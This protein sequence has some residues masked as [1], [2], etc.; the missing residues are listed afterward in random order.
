MG[1]SGPAQ[2]ST[3]T[4]PTGAAAGPGYTGVIRIRSAAEIEAAKALVWEFFDALRERYPEMHDTL[5][6]YLSE[7][8]VAGGLERFADTFLPPRGESFLALANG[9]PVGMVLLQPHGDNDGEMN[10]MFVR[11]SAR[12]LGLGRKLGQ[13][14][15]AEARAI[16]YGTVWLDAL[17][18]HV[19]ALPLY[20]SLGFEYY[21][22]PN[23]FQADDDRVIHMKLKL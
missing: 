2:D 22:D 8:D 19:E 18:R 6:A 14:L 11:D 17:Y 13:A 10:R 20:E 21:T 1:Q 3:A 5:D 15:V 16:G 9:V 7:T 12:G 4:V 23:A